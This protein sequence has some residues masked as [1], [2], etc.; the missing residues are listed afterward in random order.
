MI[1][2]F[3]YYFL[4]FILIITIIPFVNCS[5]EIPED[6]F[7]YLAP[8]F[9]I[10]ATQNGE[11][12]DVHFQGTNNEY[13]FDGYNAYVSITT[14]LRPTVPA[15]KA[16]QVKDCGSCIPSRPLPSGTYNMTIKL[17]HYYN[18]EGDPMPFSTGTYYIRLA[19][20][21]RLLGVNEDGVSNEKTINFVK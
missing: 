18:T 9:I 7:D 1:Q 20:H 12:I 19:S 8:P 2:R 17:Y 21:H 15:L 11:F 3:K 4:I 5:T 6:A 10:S 13:Y 16:V 14:M